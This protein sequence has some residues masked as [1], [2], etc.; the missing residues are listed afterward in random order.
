MMMMTHE[1]CFNFLIYSLPTIAARCLHAI[2]NLLSSGGRTRARW[3]FRCTVQR[4]Q[5]SRW[6]FM[7]FVSSANGAW[8]IREVY[9]NLMGKHLMQNISCMVSDLII[10]KWIHSFS[11]FGNASFACSI[12]WQPI[13]QSV[14]PI[15]LLS[16]LPSDCLRCKFIRLTRSSWN[17]CVWSEIRGTLQHTSCKI[18]NDPA[19]LLRCY[20]QTPKE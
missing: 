7:I 20:A 9:W 18:R 11:Y 2:A 10:S 15:L 3:S 1:R 8:N 16:K 5:D 4:A 12:Y 19:C 14:P 17:N 13:K 6:L